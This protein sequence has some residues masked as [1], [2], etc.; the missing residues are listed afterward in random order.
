MRI[1]LQHTKCV[2]LTVE[3]Y[4]QRYLEV[5][6]RITDRLTA[7]PFYKEIVGYHIFL[8]RIYHR[9]SYLYL[10]QTLKNWVI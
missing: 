6:E 5:M 10:C 2:L 1:S 4:H 7:S 8:E 3:K 9:A